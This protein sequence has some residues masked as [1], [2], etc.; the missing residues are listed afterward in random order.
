MSR[1]DSRTPPWIRAVERIYQL[2][3]QGHYALNDRENIATEGKMGSLIP[4]GLARPFIAITRYSQS[5]SRTVY[6]TQVDK[7][8]EHDASARGS[9]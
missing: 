3:I 7:S 9:V 1:T 5:R 4:Y 6:S 2:D 8:S